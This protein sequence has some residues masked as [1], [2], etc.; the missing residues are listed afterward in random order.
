MP[1]IILRPTTVHMTFMES[2][3]RFG[4]AAMTRFWGSP[5][6]RCHA[7]H[8]V[9]Y[10]F[11]DMSGRRGLAKSQRYDKCMGFCMQLMHCMGAPFSLWEE[12]EKKRKTRICCVR[13]LD[14]IQGESDTMKGERSCSHRREATHAQE[15]GASDGVD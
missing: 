7:L 3:N 9:S 5:P 11:K 14:D 10:A 1:D 8:E 2:R 12:V 6:M 13:K 15:S 4:P